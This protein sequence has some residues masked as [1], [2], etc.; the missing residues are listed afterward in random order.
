NR[1]HPLA[2]AGGAAVGG[3]RP[4]RVRP[5]LWGEG[6]AEVPGGAPGGC[7]SVEGVEPCPSLPRHL[8]PDEGERLVGR[9]ATAW[10]GWS[11]LACSRSAPPAAPGCP[12]RTLAHS[13]PVAAPWPYHPMDDGQ[14]PWCGRGPAL[15]GRAAGLPSRGL[16]WRGVLARGRWPGGWAAV[17]QVRHL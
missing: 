5:P 4:A 3:L 10:Q 13:L 1:Q 17:G 15:V 7:G 9:P 2:G 11:N 14:R 12:W 8:S 6:A 16:P